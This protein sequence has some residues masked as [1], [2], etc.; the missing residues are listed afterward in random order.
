MKLFTQVEI[1]EFDFKANYNTNFLSIGSC[2]AENMAFFLKRLKFKILSNPS[3]V[4]YNP[5]SIS[6]LINKS[7]QNHQ[8]L[9]QDLNLFD[10]LYFNY[11]FHS[12]FSNSSSTD[13][14]KE[15][16]LAI[17]KT[18]E[19]LKSVNI[20]LVTFGT[21]WVFS[22]KENGKTVANCHKQVASKFKRTRLK[23]DE[24]FDVWQATIKNIKAINPDIQIIFSVSPV[25][26][27]GDGLRENNLSK[28]VLLLAVEKIC[29]EIE[30][31]HYFPSY[32]IILDELRDYRFY[33]TDLVHPSKTASEI[34]WKKL[35]NTLFNSET[36]LLMQD[37]EK[38][39]KSL[40]H[41]AFNKDSEAY[42]KFQKH[43][44][45]EISKLKEK[46]PG[47]EF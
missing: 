35:S 28:S 12:T 18:S 32:E 8:Y 2:F 37:V 13:A 43:L 41:R 21:T 4:L 40:E 10:G 20:L 23:I 27:I 46:I 7:I 30:N 16:N 26:H 33:D 11:N 47:I 25:R 22:L 24:I 38:I 5:I 44:E 6:N 17:L 34:V 9:E 3:G 45:T 1:P 19:A 42:Q 29:T 14:L 15:M 39:N 36:I 31:C